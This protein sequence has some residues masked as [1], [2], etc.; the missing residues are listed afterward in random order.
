MTADRGATARLETWDSFLAA[1]SRLITPTYTI[2]F[3]TLSR[4]MPSG[5]TAFPRA[6]G[7]ERLPRLPRGVL[8]IADALCR[9]NPIYGQGMSAAAKQ[10]R[11]FQTVLG[12]ART[13]SACG[14]AGRFHG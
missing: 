11:L 7:G 9:F 8:P 5:T 13:G 12:Q 2:H 4:L 14:G 6:F 10:A 3:V 1:L